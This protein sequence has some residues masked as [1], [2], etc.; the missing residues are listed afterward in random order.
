MCLLYAILKLAGVEGIEPSLSESKS[1]MLPLHNT[2]S[3]MLC[4]RLGLN[5]RPNRAGAFA[6]YLAIIA[7]SPS[8]AELHGHKLGSLFRIR[9]EIVH[10]SSVYTRYKLVALTIE[11]RDQIA[12]RVILRGGLPPSIIRNLSGYVPVP[13]SILDS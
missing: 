13:D 12:D 4:P 8:T 3:Y 6:A 7:R 10:L 5:Q 9:T 11:L 2:P 1:D